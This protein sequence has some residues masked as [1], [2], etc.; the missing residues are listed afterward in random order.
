MYLSLH[1][2]LCSPC[3]A[4]HALNGKDIYLTLNLIWY[5][6]SLTPL[7]CHFALG[8][9]QCKLSSPNGEQFVRLFS[10]GNRHV[11]KSFH[12]QKH[13]ARRNE[14]TSKANHNTFLSS[15]WWASECPTG[16]ADT[17]WS[18]WYDCVA[19]H[20]KAFYHFYGMFGSR[21]SSSWR[22]S[23]ATKMWCVYKLF[24]L[25]SMHTKCLT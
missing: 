16:L 24:L 8:D 4:T 14:N 15:L 7:L 21:S 6:G 10:A 13:P 19:C 1:C 22:G 23:K 2:S 20:A 18:G 3:F 17:R 12:L 11:S 9:K 25:L 5:L